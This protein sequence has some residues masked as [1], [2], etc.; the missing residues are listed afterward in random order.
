MATYTHGSTLSTFKH[1]ITNS[2]PTAGADGTAGYVI[3]SR[4]LDTTGNQEYVCAA[5]ATAAAVWLDTV[6]GG[7]S[8]IVSILQGGTSATVKTTAADNLLPTSTKGD[9][10]YH[11]TNNIRLALGSENQGLAVDATNTIPKWSYGFPSVKVKTSDQNVNTV[12]VADVTA[13]T[14]SVATGGYYHFKYVVPYESA[15]IT[16]GIRLTVGIPAA[17]VF[18]AQARIM[19]AAD[20]AGGEFLGAITSSG[21]SVIATAVQSAASTYLSIVEGIIVPSASGTVRLQAG[22]ETGTTT[23]TVKQGTAGILTQLG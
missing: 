7:S 3:G 4:W 23:V 8:G 10:I 21:D 6:V 9:M 2:A 19:F 22:T 14:M 12:T 16:V 15:T 20:G 11:S 18:A 13:V 5:T 1:N 17:T